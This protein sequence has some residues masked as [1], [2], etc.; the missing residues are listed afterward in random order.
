M[1]I[2]EATP[3]AP[4]LHVRDLS[5]AY[6]TRP[7]GI[8]GKKEIKPVLNNVNLEIAHGEIFG[9]VGESGC[10]K[11]TLAKCILGLIDYQGEV[12][13]SGKVREKKPSVR[14]RRHRAFEIQAVF[15]NPGASLNPAKTIGWILEE[16]LKAHGLGN[17]AER[18]AQVDEMLDLVGLDAAFKTRKPRE[19]SSGQKQRAAIAA[20]LMLRPS[21]I[22]ADEPVSALDVS[23]AAQILNLF[24]D[25]NKRLDLGMLFISHNIEQVNYLC[26]RVAVMHSGI[27]GDLQQPPY[28]LHV[29][30]KV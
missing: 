4:L 6:I 22:V 15:Q 9:L 17:P 28:P 12:F 3:A 18:Q 7:W 19:L 27:A 16:P 14:S 23:V 13:F 20:A 1:E 8:F 30:Q 24:R 10:G 26:D 2:I 29:Q 25:L 5:S 21:L 11:T